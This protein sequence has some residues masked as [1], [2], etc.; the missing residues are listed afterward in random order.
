MRIRRFLWQ[1]ST[2]VFYVLNKINLKKF[3]SRVR[4]LWHS[5]DVIKGTSTAKPNSENESFP[6]THPC[7][8]SAKMLEKMFAK[9]TMLWF[10]A[11]WKYHSSL[12]GFFDG[13]SSI[14]A[15]QKL[16]NWLFLFWDENSELLLE[17]DKCLAAI[18]LRKTWVLL[19]LMLSELLLMLLPSGSFAFVS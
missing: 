19:M 3:V 15:A 10:S 13:K 18:H 17:I 8:K 5:C 16:F 14:L 1:N 11:W 4:I 12:V 7:S 2:R 6:L 9:T